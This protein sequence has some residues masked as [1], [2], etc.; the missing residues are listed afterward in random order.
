MTLTSTPKVVCTTVIVAAK[1]LG[2]YHEG[3][4]APRHVYFWTSAAISLSQC[5]ALYCLVHFY[6]GAAAP[7]RDLHPRNCSW[8]PRNVCGYRLSPLGT[9]IWFGRGSHFWGAGS[10]AQAPR[11]Y[12]GRCA[13]CRR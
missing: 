12:C 6:H 9:R 2:W 7:P 4:M 3:S 1:G 11:S 10:R 13:R 5:W 8:G